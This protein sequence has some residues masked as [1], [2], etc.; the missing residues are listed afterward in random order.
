MSDK[1]KREFTITR[2]FDAP[3]DLVFKA[4]TDP[5]L[6]A[7]WWG[8]KGV[9]IPECKVDARPGG[10]INIVMEADESFGEYKGK[11]WPM[12]GTFVE[13]DEPTKIVFSAKG[14]TEGRVILE[15]VTTVE[16]EAVKDKTQMSVHVLVTKIIDE[17]WAKKSA[18][19]G[20]EHGWKQQFDKLAAFIN[21]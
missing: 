8:Q 7:Q 1:A 17:D 4:W 18:V 14:I 10:E 20:M 12:E 11:Q 6:V 5:E 15:Y 19:P 2:T 21:K 16:F 9:F 3:R 13:I